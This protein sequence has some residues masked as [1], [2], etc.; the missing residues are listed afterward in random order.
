MRD[1]ICLV[2]DLTKDNDSRLGAIGDM[3][4]AVDK[5]G[6]SDDLLVIGGDNLFSGTLKNFL[7]FAKTKKVSPVIGVY[8]IKSKSSASNYGVIKLDA[9]KRIVDFQEK[10]AKPQSTLVAM[11]LYFF[12]KGKLGLIKKYLSSRSKKRDAMGFYI[13]W[14]RSN[15]PVYGYE[16]RGKWY[17]IGDYKF[18]NTAKKIFVG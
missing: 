9:D 3:N 8:D 18:Y 10:P 1:R 6:V 4:F 16:F 17:D 12:P 2:D 5:M 11:C 14:L 7:V 15:F 13:D